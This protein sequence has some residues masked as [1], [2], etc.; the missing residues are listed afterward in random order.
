MAKPFW[1]LGSQ[2]PTVCP[3][4]SGTVSNRFKSHSLPQIDTVCIGVAHSVS[5]SLGPHI[6]NILSGGSIVIV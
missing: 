4:L 2:V 1:E 5:P 3:R 6:I